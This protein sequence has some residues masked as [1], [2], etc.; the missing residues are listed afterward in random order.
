MAILA[1]LSILLATALIGMTI[2][3]R[4]N[5]SH[6]TGGERDAADLAAQQL[7]A[8]LQ[9]L[10]ESDEHLLS[11]QYQKAL[12]AYEALQDR[13]VKLGDSV[14]QRRI[15]YA[16]RKLAENAAPV[17]S[18]PT[19][20]VISAPA[21]DTATAL[22]QQRDSTQQVAEKISDSMNMK[23]V[24][25]SRQ[26][27]DR[28]RE[29]EQKENLQTIVLKGAGGASIHYLG[30]T[31]NNMANGTGTGVWEKSGGVYKGEWKDNQRHGQ[32]VY[33]WADGEKYD[34]TFTNDRRE[35]RGIYT[36]LSGERYEG[37]WKNNKREGQGT[38][39]DKD[40]NISFRGQW[41]NDK[42]KNR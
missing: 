38:M 42:P 40:G 32:G 31:R 26:V 3:R 27:R 2:D 41:E 34:G 29:L 7:S 4:I 30:E 14:L 39:F 13:V 24:E 25:L 1:G 36:W 37:E 19:E 22:K 23:I 20:E 10:I 6:P 9:E 12:Q 17:T 33:T 16:K 5:K 11:G 15:V 28:N 18:R 8:E 35:G 21:K